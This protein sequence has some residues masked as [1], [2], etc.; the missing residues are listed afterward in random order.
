MHPSVPANSVRELNAMARAQPGQLNGASSGIGT[1]PHLAGESNAGTFGR[2]SRSDPPN[3]STCPLSVGLPGLSRSIRTSCRYT[4]RASKLRE[5]SL[6]PSTSR[7]SAGLGGDGSVRASARRLRPAVADRL[8]S[9]APAACR[10]RPR[11]RT[12]LRPIGEWAATKSI[13]TP[14]PARRVRCAGFAARP[15]CGTR[16]AP[17]TTSAFRAAQ[18]R[19]ARPRVRRERLEPRVLLLQLLHPRAPGRAAA[20]RRPSSADPASARRCRAR[21]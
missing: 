19:Y 4:R 8:R 16:A 3:V 7:D 6:P 18:S 20:G 15:A 12:Q 10:R 1:R 11:E 17:G 13:V 5:N 21:A 9:R 2:P 14:R